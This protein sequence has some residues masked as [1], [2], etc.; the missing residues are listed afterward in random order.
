MMRRK[1]RQMFG[2]GLALALGSAGCK[3]GGASE[4]G[5]PGGGGPKRAMRY[6]VQTAPVESQKVQYTINAVGS[7]AAFEKLQVVARV[8]GAIEKVSFAEGDRV[9][10][11]QLLALV[12]PDRYGVAVQSAKAAL[13][14][15][16]A[17]KADALAGLAR[18][19][20]ADK[21]SPGLITGEELETFRTRV[22][23]ADA[24]ISAAKAALSAAMLNLRDAYVR[25]PATGVIEQRMV[26]TGQYATP[27]TVLA[28]LVQRD[29]L[30]LRFD[31]PE[32]DAQRLA[33]KMN[34]K[35][36]VHSE[37]AD[38][39]YGALISHVSEQANES[40]RMVAVTA[41]IDDPRKDDLRPGAFAEVTVPIGATVDAAVVPQT[42]VRPSEKGFLGYV[43]EGG[44]AHERVLTLGMRTAEGLV[45][46][47][48]GLKAGEQL[49]VRGGEALK[50]GVEV[51]TGDDKS[52]PVPGKG[53]DGGTRTA[54]KGG[55]P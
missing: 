4:N 47:R 35:F 6:P 46:V 7:V 10:Q 45:E 31:V 14:R 42:A 38:L 28:T 30:L 37:N 25:A 3:K 18:R 52:A 11:G 50:D 22:A 5:A 43:V 53:G 41:E 39:E 51:R 19:E 36:R 13:V 44:V 17:A 16:Q 15:A 2:I 9:K 32:G 12:E 27:G 21:A 33:N 20:S 8:S 55:R 29:P 24:D 49:V 26:Q 23:T 40:S 34:V 54:E 1:M 48:S